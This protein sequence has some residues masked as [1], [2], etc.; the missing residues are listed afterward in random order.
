MNIAFVNSTRIWSGV[1]TWMVEFGS[2]LRKQGH[3]VSCFGRDP[4]FIEEAGKKGCNAYQLTFGPDYNPFAVRYFYKTFKKLQIDITCMNIQK[5]LRTAGIAARI[6]RI[7]IVH[8][9]G[10]PGDINRKLDQR[11]AQ[12]FLVDEILVTSRWIK[13]ELTKRFDFIPEEKVCLIH[14]SKPVNDGHNLTIRRP[15]PF[16]IT[17]RLA[18]GKGHLTV[19]KAFRRLLEEGHKD[20]YCHIYGDGPQKTKIQAAISEAKL[21]DR[22]I[23]KGFQKNIREKLKAYSFGLLASRIEGFPNTV[24][25]YMSTALPCI[26]T[27]GGGTTELLEHGKNGFLYDYQ[28]DRKLAEWIRHCLQ[29]DDHAYSR[30]SMQA[31]QTMLASFELNT[32]VQHLS[33]RFLEI[34]NTRSYPKTTDPASI[35][36]G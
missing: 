19:V 8:R 9:V 11:L 5:E 24:A 15:V 32:N 16:V 18:E 14:N 21:E 10:L 6:L 35:F 29:M 20:F 23:L 12:K 25:E 33:R 26:S 22:L 36:G 30:M 4:V 27:C 3:Q 7:P 28:D 13:E 2:E 31:K 17:S 1:K 34:I